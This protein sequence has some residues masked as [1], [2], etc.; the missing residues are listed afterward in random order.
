MPKSNDCL[1]NYGVAQ[2]TTF[3]NK[4][5]R[6]FVSAIQL[7]G[8]KTPGHLIRFQ[9]R[10]VETPREVNINGK[11]ILRLAKTKPMCPLSGATGTPKEVV[12]RRQVIFLSQ[13][14]HTLL[15]SVGYRVK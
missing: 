1:I 10:L 7:A 12:F 11:K 13:L 4:L 8:R 14:I 3:R 5:L 9:S 6:T 15:P 2:T